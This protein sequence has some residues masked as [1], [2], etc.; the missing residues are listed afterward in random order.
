[1]RHSHVALYLRTTLAVLAVVSI[2]GVNV[3]INNAL[4]RRDT[5]D[6]IMDAHDAS[7]Q[8]FPADAGAG[9]D[10]WMHTVS[11]GLCN[12]ALPYGCSQTTDSCGFQFDHNVSIWRSPDLVNWTPVGLAFE[13]TARPTGIV[14]RPSAVWNAITRL[15]ILWINLD[16]PATGI[17]GYAAFTSTTA[18][19]PFVLAQPAVNLTNA[20]TG[21]DYHIFVDDDATAYVIYSARHWMAVR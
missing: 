6:V 1:M 19:G 21:G 20:T 11:Y 10:F 16:T 3:T 17:H 15:F 2:F 12:A 13:Y 18:A 4:P 5:N 8:R 14:Y 9:T 7:V